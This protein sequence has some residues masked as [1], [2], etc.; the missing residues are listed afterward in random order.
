MGLNINFRNLTNLKG[1]N[2]CN[3][4][5]Q[6]WTVQILNFR[7]IVFILILKSGFCDNFQESS[8]D[9]LINIMAYRH[10]SLTGTDLTGTLFK[11]G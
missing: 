2:H 10:R 11:G 8:R 1:V 4:Q 3:K 9:K 6:F 7:I 5:N